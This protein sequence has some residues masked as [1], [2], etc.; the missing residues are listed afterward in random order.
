M[1]HSALAATLAAALLISPAPPT[2]ER[3][4]SQ[5]VDV[6]WRVSDDKDGHCT[7]IIIGIR[8][9]LTAEHC[10]PPLGD[11][12]DVT[13]NG[14]F[15]RIVK[16]NASLDLALLQTNADAAVPIMSI[17]KD[18]PKMGEEVFAIGLA[19]GAPPLLLHTY[20]AR[21]RDDGYIYTDRTFI[22]GMSGGPVVDAQGRLIGVV[23]QGWDKLNLGGV[24]PAKVVKDF[25]DG[26]K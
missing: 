4:L 20:I 19:E 6:D 18:A 13:V 3:T 10:L 24:I 9:V 21:V 16:R 2:F 17:R 8:W 14:E 5:I 15:V 25:I 12:T 11:T 22:S 1:L 7:G 26:K 23:R